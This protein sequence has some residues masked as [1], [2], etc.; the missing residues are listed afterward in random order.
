MNRPN[1]LLGTTESFNS[2]GSPSPTTFSAAT[3]NTYWLPSYSPV[4]SSSLTSGGTVPTLCHIRRLDSRFSTTYDV[5]SAPPSSRGAAQRSVTELRVTS[6]T[7]RL[8]TAPGLSAH[9]RLIHRKGKVSSYSFP[10][11][12]PGADPGVQA[13]SPQVTLVCNQAN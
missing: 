11:V 8:L 1:W 6:F 10:S 13:V 4:A 3:R 7:A 12:G 5:T 2:A 9:V